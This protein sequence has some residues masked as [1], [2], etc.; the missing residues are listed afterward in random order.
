MVVAGYA[1]GQVLRQ[2]REARGITR[3]RLAEEAGVAVATL[4][5]VECGQ[6]EPTR[7]TRAVIA[8][9]L[10]LDPAA[11]WSERPLTG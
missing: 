5:R 9:A 1:P 3:Q 2:L 7:A 8:G 11:I 10:G 4:A 6:V